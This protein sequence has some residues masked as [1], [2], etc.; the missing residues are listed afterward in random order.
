MLAGWST[1]VLYNVV[2]GVSV[3]G[4]HLAGVHTCKMPSSSGR[5]ADLTERAATRRPG[6][7]GDGE[8]RIRASR[9]AGGAGADRGREPQ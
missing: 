3:Q 7:D 9:I 4:I 2:T 6:C 8:R 1:W 5:T